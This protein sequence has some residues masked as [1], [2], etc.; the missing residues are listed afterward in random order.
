MLRVS[1]P[2]PAR[3]AVHKLL[4]SR[5]RPSTEQAKGRKDLQQA[6]LLLHVLLE[7]RPSDVRHA[8]KD[9]SERGRN[10]SRRLHQAHTALPDEIRQALSREKIQ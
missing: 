3:F 5:E 6:A 4:I 9:A 10:W 2:D 7:E 8:W 1:I